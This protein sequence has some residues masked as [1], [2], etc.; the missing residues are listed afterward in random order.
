MGDQK[1]WDRLSRIGRVRRERDVL[2]R[3]LAAVDKA[4]PRWSGTG[5]GRVETI[6]LLIQNRHP[7]Q[8]A[9]ARVISNG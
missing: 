9:L 5:R 2:K 4:L 7:E 8:E 6:R 1:P 3:Q